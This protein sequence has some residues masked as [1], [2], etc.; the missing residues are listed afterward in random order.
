MRA[1]ISADGRYRYRLER[2]VSDVPGPTVAFVMLNPSTADAEKDDPTIR[3][4]I[5]FAERLGFSRLVVVNLFALRATDPS[6]LLADPDPEGP[7]NIDYLRTARVDYDLC[8]AAWG[9]HR[10]IRRLSAQASYWLGDIPPAKGLVALGLTKDGAPRH[11]LYLKA[12][13]PLIPWRLP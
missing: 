4:C 11:P 7:D 13:S 2:S 10:A 3:R 12:D 1:V 6:A 9:A 8:I 5:G